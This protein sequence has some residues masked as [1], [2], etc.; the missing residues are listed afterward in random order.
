MLPP[1]ESALKALAY[2]GGP[3]VLDAALHELGWRPAPPGAVPTAHHRD[4]LRSLLGVEHLL[5]QVVVGQPVGPGVADRLVEGRSQ[6]ADLDE[7][8]EVAGLEAG[9]LA[10]VGEGE[11]L[12]GP[13]GSDSSRRRPRIA[14]R[15]RIV[16]AVLRPS[17]L[18]VASLPKSV[19]LRNP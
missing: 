17:E 11:E 2:R 5:G 1:G 19:L 16:V 4:A 3:A 9:V 8:V 7:V 18:R 13:A 10:V 12:A 15:P 6:E 14:V